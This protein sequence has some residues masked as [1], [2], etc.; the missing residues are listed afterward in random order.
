MSTPLWLLVGVSHSVPAAARRALAVLPVIL[1]TRSWRNQAVVTAS[2]AIMRFT[3]G[4]TCSPISSGQQ[5]DQAQRP[6]GAGERT[7]SM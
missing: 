6:A 7:P 2:P 3:S 4:N 5:S 1:G